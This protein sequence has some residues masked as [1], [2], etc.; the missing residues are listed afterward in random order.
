MAENDKNT[1]VI[2]EMERKYI[3]VRNRSLPDKVYEKENLSF[4]FKETNLSKYD[5]HVL[6]AGAADEDI[7][8]II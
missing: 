3:E 7:E 5:S 1:E 2:K 8:Q 6:I 4:F